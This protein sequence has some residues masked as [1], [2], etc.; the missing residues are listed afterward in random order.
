MIYTG[1][2]GAD[3][4]G[5]IQEKTLDEVERFLMMFMGSAIGQIH[6]LSSFSARVISKKMLEKED[7]RALLEHGGQATIREFQKSLKR[8]EGFSSLRIEDYKL[9]D[10]LRFMNREKVLYMTLDDMESG[11][12]GIVFRNRDIEKMEE[13]KRSVELYHTGKAEIDAASFLKIYDRK[14]VGL[15]TSIT[16]EQAELFRYFIKDTP[17]MFSMFRDY[18]GKNAVIF[19]SEDGEK[20]MDAVRNADWMLRG[21]FGF[22][23]LQQVQYRIKGREQIINDIADAKKEFYI[24]SKSNPKNY[25]HVT[26][27]QITYYKNNQQ[28]QSAM[29][30]EPSFMPAAWNM[31]ESLSSPVRMA[32]NEFSE[33]IIKRQ[34]FI[35]ESRTLDEFPEDVI[36]EAEMQKMNRLRN[37]A[38]IKMGLDNE[39]QGNWALYA[40][41]VPYSEY[42]SREDMMDNDSEKEEFDKLRES[43]KETSKSAKYEE[44]VLADN[45]LESIISR[46][47]EKADKEN[48][49]EK[50]KRHEYMR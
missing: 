18:D 19:D 35:D 7:M 29:R 22:K 15:V 45:S 30:N 13:I 48:S 4:M 39:N 14:K 25:I 44:L 50:G 36:V 41:S 10:Y 3:D 33:D 28:I 38:S 5:D 1:R 9:S 43:V 27:E 2:A 40:D 17:V 49:K 32:E 8:G 21:S 31:I 12:H 24:V 23:V 20:I 6:N 37:L 47:K 42:A 34:Q 46:A 26:E 16:D 11:T